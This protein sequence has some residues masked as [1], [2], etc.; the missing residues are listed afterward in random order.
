MATTIDTEKVFVSEIGGGK[1][2]I[3][4]QED[5]GLLLESD[6]RYH[7]RN[8]NKF[9]VTRGP[10]LGRERYLHRIIAGAK[11]GQMVDHING[12]TLDNRRCNLRFATWSEN[13]LNRPAK[14]GG[15]SKFKGVQLC[16]STGRWRVM[17]TDSGKYRHIGRFDSEIE[18]AYAYDMASIQLH[19]EFGRR[20]F[21]PLC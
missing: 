5:A 10:S 12:D 1:V 18:A 2:A 9:Y 8:A 3:V 20:N 21:L 13:N 16:K 17:V 15:S 11:P 19:G 7:H 4:D 6:W 14:K